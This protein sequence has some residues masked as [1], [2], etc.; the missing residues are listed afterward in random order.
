MD[1]VSVFRRTAARNPDRPFAFDATT[2]L[3]YRE[4]DELTD[5]IGAALIEAGV[6]DGK[7]LGLCA[8]DSVALLITIIGAWKAGALP[9]L[10][11][12]RTSEADLAYFVGDIDAKL[13]VCTPELRDRLQVAGAGG[14]IDLVELT[15]SPAV[16]GAVPTMHGPDAPLYL[17][18][19]S[20][21]TGLP[22]GAILKSGPV[23]L[24]TACI[25]ERLGLSRSDVLLATTPTSSSFQLVAALMPA[26]HVGAS[27]VLVAGL[28][29]EQ[30]VT[31]ASERG[32][33]VL[34]A[35]PLTLADVV[36]LDDVGS[37]GF[38]LALSGGS[39]LAPRIKRDYSNRLGIS[40]VESYGQSE[41]GGFMALGQLTLDERALTGFVGRAL[42]DRPSLIWD[43]KGKEVA[44]GQWGEVIVPRGYFAGYMNKPEATSEAL[45]AGVLHTG[46][47]G[48]ADEDGYLKVLGRTREQG[49]AERRGGFLRDVEDAYYEYPDVKHAA[50]VSDRQGTIEAFVELLP[51]RAV[52]DDA[53]AAFVSPRVPPGLMPS[54][55][56]VL[57]TMPRSFSGK[58]DRRRLEQEV[59]S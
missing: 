4:A 17:S 10:I 37:W 23:T 55:T 28:P 38:R 16:R 39:P 42:P 46:D 19:T 52:N 5:A 47:L 32:A 15:R 2:A 30:F 18:Y 54:R 9:A 31:V 7:V 33:T 53:I 8:P 14:L 27:V 22:K 21:T 25:A 58:A 20:G 34:V 3:S 24:G 1:I 50:V 11:D 40:L 13:V 48:M 26:I 59:V 36:N 12:P 41:L 29:A 45:R 43:E 44:A 51:G 49:D 35:Y 6:A 56:T 57:E